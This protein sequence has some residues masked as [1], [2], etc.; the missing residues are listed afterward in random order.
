[1]KKGFLKYGEMHKYLVIYREAVSHM[2]LCTRSL[3]N[4]LIYEENFVFFFIS[5][6]K[7]E[8]NW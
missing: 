3:L 2:K 7:R 4:F 8:K 5:V 6:R 1:M